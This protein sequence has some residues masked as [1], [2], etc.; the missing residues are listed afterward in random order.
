MQSSDPRQFLGE[1][2]STGRERAMAVHTRRLRLMGGE[3]SGDE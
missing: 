3:A 2:I 1:I